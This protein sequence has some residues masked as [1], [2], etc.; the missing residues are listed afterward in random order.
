MRRSFILRVILTLIVVS[1]LPVQWG[2]SPT[3]GLAR[4][5][6][7]LPSTY[8]VGDSLA[9]DSVSIVDWKWWE[10]IGDSTLCRLVRLTLAH[11]RDLMQAAARVDEVRELYGVAKA[12]FYPTLSGRVEGNREVKWYHHSDGTAN[13]APD[14]QLGIKLT[15]GWEFNLFGKLNYLR[16]AASSRFVA[17]VEDMNAMRMS[18]V[19]QVASAYFRIIAL[20]RQIDIIENTVETRR[21]S[22]EK[23]RLRYEGGLTSAI[24]YEQTRTEYLTALSMLPSL[25]RQCALLKDALAILSG[26]MPGELVLDRSLAL[27][28]VMPPSLPVGVPSDLLRRRPDLR[29]S[30]ARVREAEAGVGVSF[31][32]RFP[33]IYLSFTA[34]FWNSGFSRLFRS[35]YNFPIAG[36]SGN[37]FDF[38]RKQRA[39][40]ASIARY[41]QARIGYER[42]IVNA[43]G[44]VRDAVISYGRYREE[45]ARRMELVDAAR[46][47]LSLAMLQYHAGMTSY[48]DVL[49]AQRRLFSAQI[50]Y[51]TSLSDQYLAFVQLY[52]AL[53]GG[54]EYE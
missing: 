30:A 19:A 46:R 15:V 32:D 2:C 29:A 7:A 8:A 11:N 35:P 51:A 26:V 5:D 27:D 9:A 14:P 54:W 4:P 31:A 10:I 28:D 49:D 52:K 44:E 39:Y 23:A 53:G 33:S 22:M 37:I 20:D 21:Q 1:A 36:I 41:E 18:L 47:Y 40:R 3:R 12:D 6:T 38:G 13:Y 50:D 25:Q 34:G 43:F 16:D 42:D 45:G 24:V 48:L 17:T